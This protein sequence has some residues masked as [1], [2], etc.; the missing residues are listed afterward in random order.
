MNTHSQE[1]LTEIWV[2]SRHLLFALYIQ[3]NLS[4]MALRIKDTSVIRTT[5]DGPKRSAI[6]TCTYLIKDTYL[7]RITDAW[8]DPK[9]L[10]YCMVSE[11]YNMVKAT[12]LSVG[13][14]QVHMDHCEDD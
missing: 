11:L 2:Y 13:S 6:K 7:F 12:L 10:Y 14:L 8:S 9:R 1:I 3:R 5:I 4:I